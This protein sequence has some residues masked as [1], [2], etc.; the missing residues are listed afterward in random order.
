VAGKLGKRTYNSGYMHTWSSFFFMTF[1][2]VIEIRNNL[3]AI[4]CSLLNVANVL[5]V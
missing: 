5:F 4:E 3:V 2:T 1:R